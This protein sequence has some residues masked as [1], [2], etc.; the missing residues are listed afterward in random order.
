MYKEKEK[1]A[2][3]KNYY[4]T[5]HPWLSSQHELTAVRVISTVVV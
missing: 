1:K 5:H 3:Q 4:S 2:Q